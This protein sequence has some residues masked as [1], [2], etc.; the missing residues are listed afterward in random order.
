MALALGAIFGACQTTGQDWELV[1]SVPLG[2]IHPTGLAMV[3]ERLWIADGDQQR[4]VVLSPEGERLRIYDSLDRPMHLAA[5]SSR[6]LVPEYGA[7]R[8]TV[9]VPETG[10]RRS[11]SVPDS[12]DAP[13][14]VSVH[15]SAIAIADF[16]HH[17]VLYYDGS[18]WHIWGAEGHAPGEFYYPT[19]V[20]LTADRLYVADAY[21]HRVQVLDLSDGKPTVIGEEQPINGAVGL[22]VTNQEVYVADYENHRVWVF[23]SNGEVQQRLDS[24]RH[25][26]D[27]VVC[28]DSLYVANYGDQTLRVYRR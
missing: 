26:T 23:D 24:L 13:A 10:E 25:P 15:G 11:L 5:D 3:N 6:V 2:D 27:V 19:D 12:L 18:R 4:V 22:F 14:G 8:I 9:L 28:Q 7:D 20:H 16:Y 1:R 21:N 17:R